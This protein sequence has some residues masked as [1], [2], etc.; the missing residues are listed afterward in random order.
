MSDPGSL[1]MRRIRAAPGGCAEG[2]AHDE[3]RD[4]ARCDARRRIVTFLVLTLL[5][6]AAAAS[7]AIGIALGRNVGDLIAL[8]LVWSPG[9]AALITVLAFQRNVKASV[10]G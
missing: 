10:G 6:T 7:L 4:G 1:P 5:L 2:E 8:A 9:L 3:L